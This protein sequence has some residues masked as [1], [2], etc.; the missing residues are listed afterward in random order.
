MRSIPGTMAAGT[1]GVAGRGEV[2]SLVGANGGFISGNLEYRFSFGESNFISRSFERRDSTHSCMHSHV[3]ALKR[4]TSV[5]SVITNSNSCSTDTRAC[6]TCWTV[7]SDR[8]HSGLCDGAC[9]GSR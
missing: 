5:L 4:A 9:R 8:D 7:C 6:E 1:G 2:G 3:L